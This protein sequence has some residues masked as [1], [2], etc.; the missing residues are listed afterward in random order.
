MNI[1]ENKGNEVMLA[2]LSCIQEKT[3][4]EEVFAEYLSPRHTP[5]R[6]VTWPFTSFSC[7]S[8]TSTRRREE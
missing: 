2:S 8:G 4:D 1:R 5:K 7:V 3:P 6:A